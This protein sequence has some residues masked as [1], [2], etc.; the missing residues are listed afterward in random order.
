[1]TSDEFNKIVKIPSKYPLTK[2]MVNLVRYRFKN[3][4]TDPEWLISDLNYNGNDVFTNEEGDANLQQLYTSK[5][6]TKEEWESLLPDIFYR[7]FNRDFKVLANK[8]LPL[9]NHISEYW[10]DIYLE[11]WQGIFSFGTHQRTLGKSPE[12]SINKPE[13]GKLYCDTLLKIYPI[14]EEFV[15]KWNMQYP[16]FRFCNS[17]GPYQYVGLLYEQ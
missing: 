1:M 14:F 11:I 3:R 16:L 12:E 2:S 17:I 5:V 10:D 7:D 4:K 8:V 6:F 13:N 9:F 15:E